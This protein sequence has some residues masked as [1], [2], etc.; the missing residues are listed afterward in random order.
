MKKLLQWTI[1]L[2]ASPGVFGAVLHS[3]NKKEVMESFV[4]K[5]STSIA[6]DNLNGKTID[7]TFSMFLDDRGH[8]FGKMAL[9]PE[10]GPQIDKGTYTIKADGTVYLRWE[11]WDGAKKLCFHAFNTQN[12]Y[13]NVSCDRVFHTVF[14]KDS[15]K[16]GNSLT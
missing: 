9:K 11:H 4:N 16:L 15:I 14:M 5:T 2:I 10:D 1:L 13:I 3:L 7:N 8:I 12:A 6:T